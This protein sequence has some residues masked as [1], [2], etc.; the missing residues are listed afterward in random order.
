MEGTK[1]PPRAYV[2][3]HL[4]VKSSQPHLEDN[5]NV[6]DND[7]VISG[8]KIM[9]NMEISKYFGVFSIKSSTFAPIFTKIRYKH[10]D[11]TPVDGRLR[12]HDGRL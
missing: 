10:E 12:N 3:F 6:N 8:A 1:K 11:K 2:P 5:V 4:A 9:R 7:N